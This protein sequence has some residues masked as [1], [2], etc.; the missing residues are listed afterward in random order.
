ML[1]RRKTPLMPLIEIF[2]LLDSFIDFKIEWVA[3]SSNRVADCLCKLLF[4]YLLFSGAAVS[5]RSVTFSHNLSNI[6]DLSPLPD[7]ILIELFLGDLVPITLKDLGLDL[8]LETGKFVDDE[9]EDL[10]AAGLDEEEFLFNQEEFRS[11]AILEDMKRKII[12]KI[13][14]TRLEL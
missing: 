3:R 12:K 4:A 13:S 8:K 11:G 5:F 2:G 6:T 1:L 14:V 9:D 10:P 7:H